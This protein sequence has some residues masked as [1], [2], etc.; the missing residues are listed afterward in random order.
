MRPSAA[1]DLGQLG[2]VARH[3]RDVHGRHRVRDRPVVGVLD[4]VAQ[5]D[6]RGSSCVE[7]G[8]DF[9]AQLA[10]ASAQLRFQ[11]ARSAA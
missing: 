8:R 11:R 3:E 10:L 4:P 2:E 1:F 9:A 5:A 7:L 6:D